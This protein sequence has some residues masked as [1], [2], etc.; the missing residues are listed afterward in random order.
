M[1]NAKAKLYHTT[2]KYLNS[3]P[4]VNGQIIFVSDNN[5]VCVD[6]NDKRVNYSTMH[7]FPLEVDRTLYQHPVDNF[8]FV[9]ET[10]VL[11]R[12]KEGKGWQQVTSGGLQPEIFMGNTVDDFPEEG[13]E[14]SLYAGDDA[15]Y[16]WDA[17]RTQYKA[18]ANKT[19]WEEL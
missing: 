5:S 9:E 19:G 10:N 8:Y 13:L 12:Y 16:K 6:M 4:V 7:V 15:I 11:W 17:S 2:T 14:N 3:L 1:A 18:I